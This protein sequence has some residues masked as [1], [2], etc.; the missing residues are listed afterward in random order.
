VAYRIEFAPAAERQFRRLSR[1]IQVRLKPRID[2]LAN[3]PRPHGTKKLS[4]EEDLYRIRIGDY[5]VIYQVQDFLLLI[6]V[7]KVGGRKDVYR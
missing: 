7:V 5:R 3:N 2:A 1:E 6:V 4:G